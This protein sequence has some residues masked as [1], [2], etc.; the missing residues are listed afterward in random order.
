[1]HCRYRYNNTCLCLTYVGRKGINLFRFLGSV[2]CRFY[3][4]YNLIYFGVYRKVQI[5]DNYYYR[6]RGG[7]FDVG[8]LP[9][10]YV[11][12]IL[13]I[14][15]YVYIIIIIISCSPPPR[16]RRKWR[17]AVAA[18][19]TSVGVSSG[20]HSRRVFGADESMNADGGGG[21]ARHHYP[22]IYRQC[23]C[24]CVYV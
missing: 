24:V 15:I 19:A 21:T 5:E 14:Y 12:I 20:G 8:L 9:V 16:R 23:V 17:A 6:A 22:A 13:Y 18:A 7:P 4:F 1:M 3:F 10:L 2:G 11:Y